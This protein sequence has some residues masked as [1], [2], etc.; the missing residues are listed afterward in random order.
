M[1][2]DTDFLH[3]TGELGKSRSQKK[4]EST[5][6]QKAGEELCALD[7]GALRSMGLPQDL[8]EAVL[9]WQETRSKEARRRQGQYIGRLMRELEPEGL[10]QKL[11]EFRRGHAG[12]TE[13]LHRLEELREALLD[14]NPE[15]RQQAML[16]ALR[17]Y[18]HAEESKL[19]HL[20]TLA[21]QERDPANRS[22]KPKPPKAFRELLRYLRGAEK[23]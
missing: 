5:A 22:G 19:R 14:E 13:E 11:A 23:P 17:D 18:P 6:L 16:S 9:T 1:R 12:E 15:K 20:V 3:G 2:G 8:L 7:P 4:R 10:E 21:M